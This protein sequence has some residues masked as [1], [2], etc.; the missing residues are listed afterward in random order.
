M[1]SK[2]DSQ[3]S[4]S[5]ETSRILDPLL[6]NIIEGVVYDKEASN[7]IKVLTRQINVFLFQF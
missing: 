4:L 6:R 1:V 7:N 3:T 5:A 2:I